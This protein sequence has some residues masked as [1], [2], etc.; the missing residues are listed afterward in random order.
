LLAALLAGPNEANLGD[1]ALP[2][3]TAPVPWG[4]HD[5]EPTALG[6]PT[7]LFVNFEGAVLRSGCGND[8]HYDCSTLAD[9]FDGYVGPYGGNLTQQAAILQTVR[10]HLAP[11]G[12][13]AVS[14]RPPDDVEYS[15]VLYG[16]LGPQ[17]FAGIAPYIDCGNVWKSD[18]SFSQGFKSANQGATVILQEAAHT[19]GLEHVNQPHDIMH[20]VTEGVAPTFVDECEK[21][22]S[23]TSLDESSGVC[24]LVHTKFC[25]AGHQNSQQELA[26]LFGP[27][28]ADTDPPEVVITS[29]EPESVHELPAVVALRASITDSLD[30]QFYNVSVRLDGE[31]IFAQEAYDDIDLAFAVAD[32]GEYAIELVV[33]DEAGNVGG[34]AVTF[35][36]VSEGELAPTLD[37]G[38]RVASVETRGESGRSA[39]ALA[40][41]LLPLVRRRR[42]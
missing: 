20:P 30:P 16:D 7:I 41:L 31:E 36:Y 8:A 32:P 42:R 4:G 23:N 25:D 13:T 28:V 3:G 39:P 24:N 11:L 14:H 9:T 33:T 2:N 19:W 38:C 21:I 1:A 18:T 34:D 35:T 26:W 17:G 27:P 12:V 15:M 6:E 10:K 29:P 5:V 40:L 22:V 37:G